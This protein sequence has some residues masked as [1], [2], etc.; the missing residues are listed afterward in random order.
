MAPAQSPTA[1]FAP[2]WTDYAFDFT[3]DGWTDVLTGES[4][5]MT[6]YVNPKGENRRWVG[7][8]VL[9]QITGEFTA[10]QDLDGDGTPEILFVTGGS[11]GAGGTISYAKVH[12]TDPVQPWPVVPI[13]AP[14]LA[15][16]HGLGTGDING[17]GRIDVVQAAGWWEQPRAR[18]R[19]AVA[20]SPGGVR[21]LGTGRGRRRG[22]DGGLRRQRRRAATTS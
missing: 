21:P 20:L 17:D 9:P 11:G 13:S 6:L 7:H 14:G 22:A 8:K 18:H 19:R 10:M 1:N 15:H 5:P 3:G 2:T 4:R 16:G 12:P